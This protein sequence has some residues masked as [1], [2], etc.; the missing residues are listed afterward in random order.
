MP[1]AYR[2]P[3]AY[4]NAFSPQRIT[5]FARQ[6]AV[7][8]QHLQALGTCAAS[9]NATAPGIADANSAAISLE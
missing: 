8:L 6:R 2:S 9:T 4:I 7:D 5:L 3:G 1:L